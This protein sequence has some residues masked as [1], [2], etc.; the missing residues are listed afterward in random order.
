MKWDVWP[1]ENENSRP[2]PKL[3]G[4]LDQHRG[5]VH[6]SFRGCSSC[7]AT[8]KSNYQKTFPC[9][10]LVVTVTS[11]SNLLC[12][13]DEITQQAQSQVYTLRL[14]VWAQRRRVSGNSRHA[15]SCVLKRYLLLHPRLAGQVRKDRFILEEQRRSQCHSGSG[16]VWA[17]VLWWC[18]GVK[19]STVSTVYSASLLRWL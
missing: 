19:R 13:W 15:S 18:R 4:N 9:V 12:N 14:H 7:A 11:P 1:R 5:T 17:Y 10:Q 8:L 6:L 3:E 16:S 2:P